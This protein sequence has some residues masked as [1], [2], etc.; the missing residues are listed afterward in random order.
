MTTPVGADE[1]VSP[2][3]AAERWLGYVLK[4]C[5]AESDLKTLASWAQQVAVSYTTL[6]ANC[7]I[8][9]IRP[10]DARDFMRVLRALTRASAH[11]CPPAV[12]LDVSDARTVRTLSLR[13]GLD[14]DARASDSSMAEF[15]ARQQFVAADNEGF[16]LIRD[17]VSRW[18]AH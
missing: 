6:C 4:A 16:R 12:F 13:A 15:L 5:E 7:R 8:M 2:R 3:S 17:V 9:R 1:R 14:L 11:R 10:L 18:Q